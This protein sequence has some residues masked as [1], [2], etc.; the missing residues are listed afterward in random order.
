MK[1]NVRKFRILESSSKVLDHFRTFET[2]EIKVSKELQNFLCNF[3]S[4]EVQEIRKIIEFKKHGTPRDF[5]S[6]NAALKF[7][8]STL[9]SIRYTSARST[10]ACSSVHK[11]L[12]HSVPTERD[13]SSF[14]FYRFARRSLKLG[15]KWWG[16][17]ESW[18]HRVVDSNNWK[19]FS[20]SPRADTRES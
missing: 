14:L 11:V 7:L 16:V 3:W 15:A 13:N 9:S 12:F 18:L 19:L 6:P 2:F 5:F 17:K 4:F 1:N 8:Q 10:S 20:G